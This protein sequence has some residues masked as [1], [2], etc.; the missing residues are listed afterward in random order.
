MHRHPIRVYLDTCVFGGAFDA[1]FAQATQ[2]FFEQVKQ[3][4]F[5]LITSALVME[6][7]A[8]APA[9]VQA[10]FQQLLVS[11]MT[12]IDTPGEAFDLQQ[13]YLDA[14]IVTPK[15][16]D[17][18]LHV[19]TAAVTDCALIVSWN[20]KHIV[21]FQKIPAYNAVNISQGYRALAIHSPLEVVG[22]DR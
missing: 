10:L 16:A 4:R 7:I 14:G 17:D 20:F 22:D 6:E 5:H 11:A 21:H 15:W 19:A 12:V 13:A 1:E 3:G 9:Q 8:Y 2:E 18:A